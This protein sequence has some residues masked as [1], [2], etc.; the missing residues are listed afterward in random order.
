MVVVVVVVVVVVMVMVVV[1]VVVV[2][3]VAPSQLVIDIV[4]GWLGCNDIISGAAG[5]EI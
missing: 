2:V 3:V 1:V 5:V 4:A